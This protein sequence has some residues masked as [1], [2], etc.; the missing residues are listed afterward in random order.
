MTGACIGAAK[1]ACFPPQ[2]SSLVKL[3]YGIASGEGSFIFCGS[4]S[5]AF[6]N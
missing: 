2:L 1:P 3:V 5:G 4:P 6:L